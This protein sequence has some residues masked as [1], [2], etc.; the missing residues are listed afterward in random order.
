MK[1]IF[2][3]IFLLSALNTGAQEAKIAL[4]LHGGAGTITKKNI[5]PEQEAQIR[6]KLAEALN[7][8]YQVLKYGGT[9]IDACV[10]SIAILE[11]SP[12]FNA[13]K[14]AVFTSDGQIELDCSLMDGRN[15]NAGAAS[16]VKHVKNPILLAKEIMLHSDHVMLS[17]GGADS[18]AEKQ[19]LAMV[20]NMYFHTD[21]RY[22]SLKKAQSTDKNPDYKFG[23][24]GAVALDKNGN[25]AAGTSTGG[26][27][28][29]KY[30]RIGDSPI[31]GAG[32][33]A[34]NSSCGVSCTGHGEYFIRLGVA[35]EV[36]SLMKYSNKSLDVAC[37]IVI[38]KYL[39]LMGGS[40]GLIALDKNGNVNWTFNTEGMYR[41]KIDTDG[42]I[43]IEIYK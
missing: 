35:K 3:Y 2:I 1:K 29:K 13:G 33:Y 39:E 9:S 24:V 4:V 42:K 8:G 36:S 20:N 26:M 7:V 16:G 14:G 10:E 22:Q 17:G 11:D 25:I 41:A 37:D 23:T 43:T 38:N 28:N 31:I 34:D 21:S 6:E 40:G 12:L 5:T 27:T 15:L 30:G 18:F 32:T 19:G